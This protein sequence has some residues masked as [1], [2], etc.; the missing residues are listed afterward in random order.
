L[1]FSFIG[2][3]VFDRHRQ[4]IAQHKHAKEPVFDVKYSPNGRVLAAADGEQAINL[5]SVSKK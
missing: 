2:L 4:V 1:S 3:Q 5:Y